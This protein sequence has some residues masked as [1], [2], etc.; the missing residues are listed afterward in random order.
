MKQTVT[1][2]AFRLERKATGQKAYQPALAFAADP[3]PE[4]YQEL[5]KIFRTRTEAEGYA[6]RVINRYGRLLNAG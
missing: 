2:N 1:I 5:S 3:Q 6:V 4:D